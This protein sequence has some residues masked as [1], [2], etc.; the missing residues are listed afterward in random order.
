M[1]LVLPLT[2]QYIRTEHVANE[3]SGLDPRIFDS[4][5]LLKPRHHEPAMTAIHTP[6]NQTLG[7][8]FETQG[9]ATNRVVSKH[10]RGVVETDRAQSQPDRT[11]FQHDRSAPLAR[12]EPNKPS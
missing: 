10:Y 6:P 9:F 1:L 5:N 7:F 2:I 12:S 11:V 4:G 8:S 3:L